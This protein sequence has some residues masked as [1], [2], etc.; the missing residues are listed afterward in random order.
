MNKYLNLIAI[1]VSALFMGCIPQYPDIIEMEAYI[2][3]KSELHIQGNKIWWHHLEFSAPGLWD[4]SPEGPPLP[5]LINGYEWFPEWPSA[6]NNSFCLCDSSVIEADINP[7][8]E[9]VVIEVIEARSDIVVT[10]QTL[11]TGASEAIITINDDLGG[12]EWYKFRIVPESLIDQ[13][14]TQAM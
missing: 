5:T 10:Q 14:E 11:D 2:D 4:H 12:A 6:G 3:G 7:L 9:N 8:N 1:V 13:D